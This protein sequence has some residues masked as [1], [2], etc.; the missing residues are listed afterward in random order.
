[1]S[2]KGKDASAAV[3]MP[4][5]YVA[6]TLVLMDA[7]Q[8]RIEGNYRQLLDAC[9]KAGVP[10]TPLGDDDVSKLGRTYYQLWFEK[11][12]VAFQKDEWDFELEGDGYKSCPFKVKHTS[13]RGVTTAAASYEMNLVANTSVTEA[14]LMDLSRFAADEEDSQLSAGLAK[15]GYQR[16]GYANDAGQR[17]L[18]W[19][20]PSGIESCTWSEGVKWGFSPSEDSAQ[21][22]SYDPGVIVLWVTPA[23]GTGDKLTTQKMTV[24][25]EPFDDALFVPSTG[26]S[27]KGVGL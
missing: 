19:R 21:A 7:G 15:L 18:R 3:E 4:A 5:I 2:D 14:P 26:L 16:L 23:N 25:G 1:V 22:T 20:D 27:M 9:Q 11:Q 13:L 24:G 12:R 6:Q 10:V 17:C 8:P